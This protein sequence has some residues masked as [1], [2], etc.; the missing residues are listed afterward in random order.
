MAAIDWA[1]LRGS[2][3]G[4]LLL[5][6][7]PDYEW[8]RKPFIARFDEILPQAVVM[9]ADPQDVVEAL[10]FARRHGIE[11][12]LRSGGHCFAGYSSS[13]GM[14]INVTPMAQ[15]RVDGSRAV[16][17]AG[18]RIGALTNE[19]IEHGLVVPGGSCP[20]VGIGGTTLGGGIG[21]LGRLYGLTLD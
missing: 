1:A 13:R 18:T 15:V 12:A 3:Q 21:V 17:G 20:S 4:H 11:F 10:A 5:D 6:S 19:L 7:D 9:A 8:T 2:L 16:V 14:V